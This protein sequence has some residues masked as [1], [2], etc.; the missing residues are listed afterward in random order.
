MW[1]VQR[2]VLS[3]SAWS[4][5]G[6]RIVSQHQCRRAHHPS[7]HRAT[8]GHSAVSLSCSLSSNTRFN[9]SRKL[10][11]WRVRAR[12]KGI[13]KSVSSDACMRPGKP[14]CRVSSWLCGDTSLSPSSWSFSPRSQSVPQIG[15]HRIE[16]KRSRE[17][18]PIESGRKVRGIVGRGSHG[19]R[20]GGVIAGG[21]HRGF[22][23]VG[24]APVGLPGTSWTRCPRAT[25]VTGNVPLVSRQ[26]QAA[27]V[28]LRSDHPAAPST[29]PPNSCRPRRRRSPL[30][31]SVTTTVLSVPSSVATTIP[32]SPRI[33]ATVKPR[34]RPPCLR[35]RNI[36][37][38]STPT[39]RGNITAIVA[40]RRSS[41]ECIHL[42]YRL[43][44]FRSTGR[45]TLTTGW[46]IV[47]NPFLFHIFCW[48][49]YFLYPSD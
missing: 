2:I 44:L 8:R 45:L 47:P 34:R 35:R 37:G 23:W 28:T 40:L 48:Y 26:H 22:E 38:A 36:A 6:S 17:S 7:R 16:R 33:R 4:W 3:E 9:P 43:F 32:L 49:V 25:S 19:G 1:R 14:A 18:A 30:Y 10:D 20:R 24:R 39:T 15:D 29:T 21:D 13:D 42:W 11:G 46:Y 27:V 41:G 31:I 5:D 12:V